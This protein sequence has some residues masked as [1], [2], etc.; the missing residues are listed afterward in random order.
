MFDVHVIGCGPAGS[1]CA[2]EL[3][4]AGERV[5]VSEE[6]SKPGVPA[7]C[8]G[9]ISVEGME[10]LG[11]GYSKALLNTVTGARIHSPGAGEMTVGSGV[12]RAHVVD[13]PALDLL[14]AD[15]A[16]A[17]GAKIETGRRASPH[18]IRGRL[19]VGA[20]GAGSSVAQW[21]G[22]PRITEFAACMQADFSGASMGD[23]KTLDMFLSNERFPGFF[24]WVIPTG[25][26]GARAGMGAYLDIFS[27]G[28]PAPVARLFERFLASGAVSELL[29]G[30]RREGSLAGIIPMKPREATVKGNALLVGDAA[31][32]VKATTGGG[33]VFGTAAARIAAKCI[34]SRNHSAYEAEWRS[35]LGRD[36]SLHRR[37]RLFSN[38]LT[39]SR[40]AS[41]FSMAKLLG[42]ES[43][44]NRFGDMDRP[45]R[46]EDSLR[47]NGMGGLL[48]AYSSRLPEADGRLI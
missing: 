9:L 8:S 10:S 28:K 36:L 48:S 25:K 4:K 40:M 11:I 42:A 39:D 1:V 47:A 46:M 31:G 43:F 22:F 21:F 20:D 37:L 12:P 30:A 26:D 15:A 29:S 24:G 6:H 45:G 34:S 2:R 44:L 41:L 14:L 18:S 3:A 32:Q 38:S 19:V 16:E 23:A 33:V 5:L 27:A 35:E 13:R 7:Q 17:E